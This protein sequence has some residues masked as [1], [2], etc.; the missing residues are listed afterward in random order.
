MLLGRVA[1]ANVLC[2]SKV[3]KKNLDYTYQILFDFKL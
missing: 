3:K 1:P 2:M